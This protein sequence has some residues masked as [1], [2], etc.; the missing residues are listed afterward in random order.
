M[1]KPMAAR[2]LAAHY[3]VRVWN[4]KP[5]K[6]ASLQA[7]GAILCSTV[8]QAVHG[9]DVVISML[10]DGDAVWQVMAEA[11]LRT[12]A[13]G[14]GNTDGASAKRTCWIDMSSTQQAQAQAF[15]Q[16]CAKHGLGFID[17]PVSGGVVGAQTGNLAIM[18]GGSEAD[19]ARVEALLTV[20]GRP[21]RVGEVGCGQLAKLCNQLIVGASLQMVAEALLLAQ[22]GGADPAAVRQAIRGGFA[23]SKILEVHGQ[24][25]LDRNFLPGGQVK[26]QTKDMENILLAAQ[27]AK[28]SL[29]MA[30]LVTEQYRHLLAFAPQADHSAAL[31]GLERQ[32]PGQRLGTGTDRLPDQGEA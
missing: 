18:A 27:A 30:Q 31:L 5:E 3:P 2:L 10:S 6:A 29:P 16:H 22:A 9:A 14:V 4:R 32:N 8:A 7:A 17:A 19:F 21:T 13:T 28:L 15:A 12:D 24:R 1:G 23:E 25:M 20:L 26:S 11:T